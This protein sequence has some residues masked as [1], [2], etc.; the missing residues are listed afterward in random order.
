MN[1][2]GLKMISYHLDAAR[3]LIKI[4]YLHAQILTDRLVWAR[5]GHVAA[6]APALPGMELPTG[7]RL[8]FLPAL[9]VYHPPQ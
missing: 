5:R 3:V 9:K 7:M 4:S 8:V 1:P 2:T 6:H